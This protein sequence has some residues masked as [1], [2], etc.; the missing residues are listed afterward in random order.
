MKQKVIDIEIVVAV[1]VVVEKAAAVV[2]VFTTIAV[3]I[4]GPTITIQTSHLA[5]AASMLVAA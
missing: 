2:I 4:A 1:V 5:T 3:E